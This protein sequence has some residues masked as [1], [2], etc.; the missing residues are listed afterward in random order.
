MQE[1][2]FYFIIM[3]PAVLLLFGFCG[4]YPE[5]NEGSHPSERRSA[6]RALVRLVRLLGI[7]LHYL[8]PAVI[9]V[10]DIKSPQC[11]AFAVLFLLNP[12]TASMVFIAKR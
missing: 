7:M 10:S 5:F 8:L 1:R 4:V 3:K 2:L 12:Q 6:G 9:N 11:R